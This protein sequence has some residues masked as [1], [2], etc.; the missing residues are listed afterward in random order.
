VQLLHPFGVTP[1]KYNASKLQAI[2][3]LQAA[4]KT[5]AASSVDIITGVLGTIVDIILVLI[6]SVYLTVDGERLARWLREQAPGGQRRQVTILFAIINQVVG[7][8]IRGTLTLAALIG[9]LVGGGM[10]V[11]GVRY[12]VLL[13]VLAFFMEFIPVVG[14]LISGAV[15]VGLALTPPGGII[16]ALIVLAYFVGVHI[17]EGDVVGPRIVGRA[18]GIHPATALIAFVA[19]TEIFGVWGALFAAPLAGLLQAIGIAAWREFHGGNAVEVIENVVQRQAVEAAI[20]A[21]KDVEA[22]E[23]EA[24]DRPPPP[25]AQ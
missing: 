9:V 15:S 23:K 24:T 5:I 16:K 17:I 10:T 11:L 6:L 1:Q 22:Q 4:G 21:E 20:E 25:A 13:G 18:V 12:G 8:Y 14:V 19:G 3:T 2:N 7:G